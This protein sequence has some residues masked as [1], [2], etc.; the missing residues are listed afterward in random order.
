MNCRIPRILKTVVRTG[1]NMLRI[2]GAAWAVVEE[3]RC[4]GV[5]IG[6]VHPHGALTRRVHV[7][8][9]VG[10]V[11]ERQRY[12]DD[13]AVHTGADRGHVWR[14]GAAA[15][16]MDLGCHREVAPAGQGGDEWVEHLRQRRHHQ[17]DEPRRP[18]GDDRC[19]V[20]DVVVPYAH[21]GLQSCGVH[22]LIRTRQRARL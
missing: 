15:D 14:A 22:V 13:S 12:Q 8:R 18:E 11:A 2:D 10:S 20:L 9:P 3:L 7:A 17:P 16:V 5:V 19:R 1:R 6:A 4:D 21:R